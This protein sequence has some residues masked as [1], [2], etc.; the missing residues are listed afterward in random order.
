MLWAASTVQEDG[1]RVNA[2][3]PPLALK[4]PTLTIRK[5]SRKALTADDLIDCGAMS[6]SMAEFV[7]R[8]VFHR[9]NIIISGG[10][11]SG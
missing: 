9:K 1:S 2:V 11:G 6:R 7:R 4:G 10:T 3:I 5:F 8:C